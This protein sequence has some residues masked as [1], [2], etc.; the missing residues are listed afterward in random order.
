MQPSKVEHYLERLQVD[1]YRNCCGDGDGQSVGAASKRRGLPDFGRQHFATKNNQGGRIAGT[2]SV[3]FAFL[4]KA[5]HH[6][7]LH[8]DFVLARAAS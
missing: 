7:I 4:E 1:S 5:C 3:Y 6:V 8:D 2:R